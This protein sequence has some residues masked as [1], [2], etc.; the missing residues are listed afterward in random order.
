MVP[1]TSQLTEGG[2]AARSLSLGRILSLNKVK[3]LVYAVQISAYTIP[4]N[5]FQ[6]VQG[7]QARN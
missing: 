4:H 2:L 5:A 1:I 6:S 3:A 7:Y